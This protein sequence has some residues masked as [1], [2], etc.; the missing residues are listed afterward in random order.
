MR[1]KVEV[2]GTDPMCVTETDYP[3]VNLTEVELDA[4]N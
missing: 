1:C 3:F 2:R 4:Q